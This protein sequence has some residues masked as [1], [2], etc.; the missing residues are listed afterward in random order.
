[1]ENRFT[2]L[3]TFAMVCVLLSSLTNDVASANELLDKA[4]DLIKKAEDKINKVKGK[5]EEA[6]YKPFDG[7]TFSGLNSKE[8]SILYNQGNLERFYGQLAAYKIRVE[9]Q[10]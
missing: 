6:E 1:M 7:F 3:L 8:D 4:S 5:K 10:V 2:Y 9:L